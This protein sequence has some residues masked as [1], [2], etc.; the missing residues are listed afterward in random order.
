VEYRTFA[1]CVPNGSV[2]YYCINNTA[3]G[4]TEWEVGYGTYSSNTL[5]RT[6]VYSSTNANALVDFSAGDK[7]VFITYPA[8]KAIY[9]EVSGETIIDGGP[10]TVIG[11]NVTSFTS[12]SSTLAELYANEN[13]FAQ[14]YAQNLN[15]GSDAS[16]DIAAY[17]NLGDGTFFFVDMGITG[18]NYTS[19]LNPIF[20]PNDAYVYS[21]GNATTV[22]RLL[23]GTQS[24]AQT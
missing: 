5:T 12:F 16:T 1:S 14:L 9:E 3:A 11:P 7:E 21:Y 2:V 18:S 10:I 13:G 4:L 8:E 17:N 15:N 19:L 22:S 6:S 24:Q 20:N 23:L